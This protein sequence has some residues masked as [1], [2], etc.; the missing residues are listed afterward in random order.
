MRKSFFVLFCAIVGLT[1]Q[2]Q[3]LDSLYSVWLD[4]SKPVIARATAYY[5]YVWDRYLYSN[6]DTAEILAKEL[7]TFAQTHK[8]TRAA[9]MAYN[10]QGVANAM[11][12]NYPIALDN[13]KKS[14]AI[15]ER[16]GYKKGITGALNNIGNIYLNQGNYPQAL[17]YYHRS[18]KIYEEIAD[19]KGIALIL[20]NIG[21]IY[22]L[23][24]DYPRSLEYQLKSLAVCQEI[25]D[26]RGAAS[27]MSN[28]GNAYLNLKNYP[29]ALDYFKKALRFFEV[30]GDKTGMAINYV[31]IGRFYED[32][33]NYTLALEYSQKS[34]E[35]NKSMGAKQPM[36]TDQINI[37]RQYKK[38]G[39]YALALDYCRGGLLLAEE[40][41]ALKQQK[42]ACECLYETHK[43]SGTS[44]LALDYHEQMIRLNDSINNTETTRKIV[45]LD[46]QY[47]FDKKE[48]IA[49]AEQEKKDAVTAQELRR[50]KLVRNGFIGGFAVVLLFA[51]VF[52]SQRNRIGKEKKRSEELLLNILPEET[53]KE[54]KEKGHSDA[55]LVDD[56]TVLFTD[57]EGFTALSEKVTPQELVADLHACFSAF[58]RLCEKY[59]IE[60]IKTIGDAYMA[61]GGLPTPKQNHAKDT[62]SLALEMAEVVE[63]EKARKMAANLP[64]FDIRIGV[65]TGPVVAGIVGIKKFQY[66]IWGDTVN[67]ASRMEASGVPGKVNIS[68]ATYEQLKEDPAFSLISR[69]KIHVKGKGEMEMYFVSRS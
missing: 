67:T 31:N 66:D 8:F 42:A 26:K 51:G 60:K 19:K 5:D 63:I 27:A 32:Q 30:T 4:K 59:G 15:D 43:A 24:K 68:Q 28:I 46:M 36:A 58:D 49:K 23:M 34:L 65:H 21:N 17:D 55:Q 53:A 7:H 45:Q 3:N 14:L 10:L 25:D 20:N 18:L 54:L 38:L 11:K 33:G 16:N 29:L 69:G 13:Y 40:V 57:F 52:L 6:P 35:L 62:V 48:T 9:A 41:G 37:G 61:A 64:Y 56:V 2:A 44:K 39:K 1:L 12:G 22:S 47:A 50:Q